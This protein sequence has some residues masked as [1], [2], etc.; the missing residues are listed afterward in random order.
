MTPKGMGEWGRGRK[1]WQGHEPPATAKLKVLVK[2]SMLVFS[3]NRFKS[4]TFPLRSSFGKAFPL[5]AGGWQIRVR[6]VIQ[7]RQIASLGLLAICWPPEL[8]PWCGTRLPATPA[9]SHAWSGAG[10]AHLP[11]Q[12]FKMQLVSHCCAS[13]LPLTCVTSVLIHAHRGSTQL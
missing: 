13:I 4:Y 5:G 11:A 3:P 1:S 8:I 7:E 10:P 12:P 6:P 2:S 9:P